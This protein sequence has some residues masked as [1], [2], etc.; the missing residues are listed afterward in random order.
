MDVLLQVLECA[1]TPPQVLNP[2]V[3]RDLQTICLK[4]LEKE[5]GQRYATAQALADDLGRWLNGESIHARSYN[6]L[7]RMAA[8]LDRSQYDVHFVAWG[9]MLLGFAAVIGLGHVATTAALIARPDERSVPL[10]TLIHLA[11]FAALL[12]LFWRN[13]PEGLM[14]RTT[15]ERQL[16]CVLGGFV[17]ACVL[18]GLVDRL[19]SAPE[20][21]HEPL[22]MYPAFTVLSGLTFLVLGSSY[23]GGVPPVC[24]RLLGTGLGAPAVLGTGTRGIRTDVDGGAADHWPATAAAGGD[25]ESHAS[26]LTEGVL[27]N[28]SEDL[29]NCSGRTKPLQPTG[30]AARSSEILRQAGR[31]GS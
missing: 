19:M 9:S 2:G 15:P 28:G 30:P 22:R 24:S 13:R 16:W 1:P 17:A 4:C 3:P 27:R 11:M 20:R 5:P 18:W 29:T 14:P 7:D 8:A 21:P 12:V 10:V 25:I 31:P 6:L 23:W 26:S